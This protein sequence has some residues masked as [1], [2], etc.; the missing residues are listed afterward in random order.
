M[1]L[2]LSRWGRILPRITPPAPVLYSAITNPFRRYVRILNTPKPTPK[3]P[4]SCPE[5]ASGQNE[6]LCTPVGVHFVWKAWV[7][8]T[9]LE[10][11]KKKFHPR[12]ICV[13]S[14]ILFRSVENAEIE[15][16]CELISTL[17]PQ[18]VVQG[19]I[20]SVTKAKG[21]GCW[22]AIGVRLQFEIASSPHI[23]WRHNCFNGK[24]WLCIC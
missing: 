15:D 4:F 1:G 11:N 7:G 5:L 18:T 2:V 24:C 13:E 12:I 16:S 17:I 22:T 6:L 21:M 14:W 20:Q 10:M 3:H 19:S 23:W 8:K 9:F